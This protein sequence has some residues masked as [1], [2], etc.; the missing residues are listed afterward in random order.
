MLYFAYGSNMDQAT[1]MA[2]CPKAR[3]EAVAR[4]DDHALVFPRSSSTRGCGVASVAPAEG[5]QV[6]GVL[7]T[8]TKDDL[9]RLD[10]CEG[11]PVAY[12]RRDVEVSVGGSGAPVAA[13]TYIAKAQV[14]PPRPN[15]GY[16][17]LLLSGA[18]R[19]GL[20]EAYIRELERIEVG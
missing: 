4:L 14:D 5:R 1:M 10:A 15:V 16:M 18:R 20:P 9:E 2:R 13:F 17:G 8:I 3:F 19:W 7:Y 11:Y 6:W 12:G